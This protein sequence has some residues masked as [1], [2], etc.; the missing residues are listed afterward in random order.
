M[1]GTIVTLAGLI[2]CIPRPI[3][4]VHLAVDST[5]LRVSKVHQFKGKVRLKCEMCQKEPDTFENMAEE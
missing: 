2:L 4:P 1:T 5:T 3:A